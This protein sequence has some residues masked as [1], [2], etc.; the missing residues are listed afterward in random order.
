MEE[1][2]LGLGLGGVGSEGGFS[3]GAPQWGPLPQVSGPTRH[4]LVALHP[5]PGTPHPDQHQLS[6]PTNIRW[7]TL[8]SSPAS[9]AGPYLP[10]HPQRP[11]PSA[12]PTT[13]NPSEQ[14]PEERPC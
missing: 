6:S 11:G 7:K 10:E 5:P 14:R 8:V 12:S 3:K 4:L 9:H 1:L 2:C 13:E